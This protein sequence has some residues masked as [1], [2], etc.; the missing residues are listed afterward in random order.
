MFL[1]LFATRILS[2]YAANNE[3]RVF[4]LEVNAKSLLVVVNAPFGQRWAGF[5]DVCSR[6][7]KGVGIDKLCGARV[8]QRQLVA[9]TIHPNT[10]VFMRNFQKALQDVQSVDDNLPEDSVSKRIFCPD[11][12]VSVIKTQEDLISS[13]KIHTSFLDDPS[14]FGSLKMAFD[15]DDLIG[16][17]LNLIVWDSDGTR[18]TL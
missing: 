15:R 16:Q 5:L 17:A 12:D 18:T 13:F 11:T 7:P 1:S 4:S 3:E 8:I 2:A 10:P 14:K 9:Y 6:E